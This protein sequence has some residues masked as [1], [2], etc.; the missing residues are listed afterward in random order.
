[1]KVPKIGLLL[2]APKTK[3]IYGF[4]ESFLQ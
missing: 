3:L 4:Y 1:V 2:M